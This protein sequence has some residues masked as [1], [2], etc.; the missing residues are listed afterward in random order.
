M[1]RIALLAHVQAGKRAPGAADRVEGA[2]LAPRQDRRFAE[3]VGDDLLRLLD[4]FLRPLL[5]AQPADRKR[6]ALADRIALDVDHLEATAAEVAGDAVRAVNAGD[7]AERG[8]P[9][10][11]GAGEHVDRHAGDRLDRGDEFAAVRGFARRR[12]REHVHL[13]DGKF[14]RQRLETPDRRKRRGNRLGIQPAAR[15]DAAG[16]AAQFLLVEERC[17][18]SRQALI[19]HQ[20][21]RVRP[22]V[23]HRDRPRAVEAPGSDIESVRQFHGCAGMGGA[24][25]HLF[26]VS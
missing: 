4:R 8:E 22:D 3:R 19:G 1:Q 11:L 2:S 15:L 14:R 26:R 18:R 6:L 13:L 17:C 12:R 24:V 7:D 9:R 10:L 23:D 20:P 21:H 25:G 5:E 16:K